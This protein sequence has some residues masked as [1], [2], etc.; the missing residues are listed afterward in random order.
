M[1]QHLKGAGLEAGRGLCTATSGHGSLSC[2]FKRNPIPKLPE[3]ASIGAHF[4]VVQTHCCSAQDT[5]E[6]P[7]RDSE[8]ILAQYRGCVSSPPS[9]GTIY[10][11]GTQDLTPAEPEHPSQSRAQGL[12]ALRTDHSTAKL[13]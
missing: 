11:M 4:S 7:G 10:V 3:A 5:A 12:Q 13:L 2:Y 6:Q 8:L 9:P 1:E